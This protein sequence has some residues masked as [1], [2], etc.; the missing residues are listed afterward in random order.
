[1]EPN[2]NQLFQFTPTKKDAV[3]FIDKLSTLA[4]SLYDIKTNLSQKIDQTLT[5]PEK[6]QLLTVCQKAG[7]NLQD[8]MQF[9]KLVARLKEEITKIP[10]ISLTIAVSPTPALLQHIQQWMQQ[11]LQTKLFLDVQVQPE[12]M[13][14]II[15]SHGG[16]I[17]EY[18]LR[19]LFRAQYAA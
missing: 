19:K 9:Q 4:D 15:I 6:Q 7:I 12:I 10:S 3:I 14:G 8:P 2:I 18:S 17:K 11:T 13:G 5:I 16:K 1:M